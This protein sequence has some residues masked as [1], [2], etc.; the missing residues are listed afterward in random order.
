L[1]D[2]ITAHQWRMSELEPGL[3]LHEWETRWS[4]LEEALREDPQA[5]LPEACDVIEEAVGK[6]FVDDD[7]DAALAAARDTALRVERGEDVDP[8]DVGA[9]VENLRAIRERIRAA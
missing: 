1:A 3:D 2:A 6:D 4:E 7:L 8:G 9:A 5:A